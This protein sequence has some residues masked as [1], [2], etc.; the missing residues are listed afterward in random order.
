MNGSKNEYKLVHSDDYLL[1]DG[2]HEAIIDNETWDKVRI[3]RQSTG[4]KAP[5]KVGRERVH[6]L[7]GLLRCPKCV[8]PMYC[9]RHY[10]TNKDG[11][12]K[13][14]YYYFADIALLPAEHP[15]IIMLN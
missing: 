1:Y 8:C 2:Q 15:A 3:K 11:T 9:N 14:V 6:L 13:D 10:W 7:S 12:Y 5:S 4:V